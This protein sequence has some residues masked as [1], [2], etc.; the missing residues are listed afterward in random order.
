MS[1]HG[2]NACAKRTQLE[3]VAR[4]KRRR[5]RAILGWRSIVAFA[6][7]DRIEIA[8]VVGFERAT[9]HQAHLDVLAASQM[10]ALQTRGQRGGV[11]R[12]HEVAWPK[13][14]RKRA[15]RP[16]RYSTACIDREK[17]R[18]D[19]ALNGFSRGDHAG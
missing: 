18:I 19:R 7:H 5:R 15:S 16:M 17:L 6:E 4:Y 2:A 3:N 11:V 12:D 14:L 1:E 9:L 8:N 13:Q 10:H